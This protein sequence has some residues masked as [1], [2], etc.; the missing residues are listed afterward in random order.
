MENEN[1]DVNII[2]ELPDEGAFQPLEGTALLEEDSSLVTNEENSEDKA[3]ELEDKSDKPEEKP[4]KKELLKF[5]ESEPELKEAMLAEFK[6]ELRGQLEKEIKQSN[7][8]A[9]PMPVPIKLDLGPL[10]AVNLK[11]SKK[12][13]V[14]G[15]WYDLPKGRTKVPASIKTILLENGALAAI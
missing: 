12:I 11:C 5:L 10:V 3:E 9:K 8:R 1:N 6:K 14:G 15:T 13:S 2:G 4:N 7:K